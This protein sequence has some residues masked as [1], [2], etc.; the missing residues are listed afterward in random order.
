MTNSPHV[1]CVCP[2]S[3]RRKKKEKEKDKRAVTCTNG[4][5]HNNILLNFVTW[6]L[7]KAFVNK[8]V[9]ATTP[10]TYSASVVDNVT[11]GCCKSDYQVES[12]S[13]PKI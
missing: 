5:N 3:N 10:V 7:G 11:I 2:Q 13:E 4:T 6:S 1:S 8:S 12:R 9:G